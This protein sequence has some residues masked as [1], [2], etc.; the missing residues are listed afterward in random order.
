MLPRD[1]EVVPAL[2]CRGLSKTYGAGRIVLAQLDFV[3]RRGEF[4]AIMG[5][6]GVGKSTLLNLIAGLDHADG[7]EVVIDGHPIARLD[8]NAATRL[9]RRKLGFVFQAFHVLPHLT[10]AQ[11]VALPLLLN[12]MP[13][14][15]ALDMLAAV[16]LG[17]RGDDFPRQLSGGELQRVA[18]ARALVHRPTLILADEPTGNLDP[19]TAHEVLGLFRAQSK[20]TGAATIMVTHS[21][22]AAAVADRVLILGDGGLH[23]SVLRRAASG[24]P[25]PST[26]S[27]DH[28]NAHA[29][30]NAAPFQT[31]SAADDR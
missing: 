14:S 12:D 3:L 9:R 4:V 27:T 30:S 29:D 25:A 21:E 18:I 13:A 24:S 15:A 31:R 10:L 23:A 17:G 5:D 20:A 19:D 16:G 26:L 7:G 22:A 11:N 1:E 2:E 8:D 6:S 28:A